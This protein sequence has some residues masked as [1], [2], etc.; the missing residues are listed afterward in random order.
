MI[1]TKTGGG[2]IQFMQPNMD[3]RQSTTTGI[4]TNDAFKTPE[5]GT[6][7]SLTVEDKQQLILKGGGH[8]TASPQKFNTGISENNYDEV[9]SI[10][11]RKSFEVDDAKSDSLYQ[12]NNIEETA[13]EQSTLNGFDV[14]LT[15]NVGA[16]ITTPPPPPQ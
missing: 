6:A 2:G 16:S 5:V 13:V 12:D 14:S 8:S 10:R 9:A 7:F 3:G 11:D 1:N 4:L 15:K